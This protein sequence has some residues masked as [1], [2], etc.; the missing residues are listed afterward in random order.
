M[1]KKVVMSADDD[2]DDGI[3]PVCNYRLRTNRNFTTVRKPNK[4][5][6]VKQN[7]ELV[8]AFEKEYQEFIDM[9]SKKIE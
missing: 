1:A 4:T 7:K 9:L 5:V 8:S 3:V 6:E 2:M